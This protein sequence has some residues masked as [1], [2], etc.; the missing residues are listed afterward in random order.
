M[1]I[2]PFLLYILVVFSVSCMEE[3]DKIYNSYNYYYPDTTDNPPDTLPPVGVQIVF[4]APG[5]ILEISYDWREVSSPY[6]YN[7]PMVYQTDTLILAE[8]MTNVTRTVI[9][10]RVFMRS[11]T[12]GSFNQY[13]YQTFPIGNH[14]FIP[15]HERSN[16]ETY[17]LPQD[18]NYAF[19]VSV[20]TDDSVSYISP[21]VPFGLTYKV[22]YD[23][24]TT[25]LAPIADTLLDY[26]SGQ[27]LQIE[28]CPASPN[29]DS[30]VVSMRN[31]EVGLV[32]TFS[33]SGRYNETGT[34]L[35]SPISDYSVW[36]KAKNTF[37]VSAAS[38]TMH[39]HTREPIAPDNLEASTNSEGL[40][41][42][43]WS[44]HALP[45]AFL[46]SRCDTLSEW[47]TVQSI[48]CEDYYCPNSYTDSTAES[49][50]VYYYRI[51]IEYSVGTWWGLDS[52]G[53]W[54]P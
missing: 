43:H 4:P 26:N 46:I 6:Y 51:G 29:V 17:N 38:D 14:F 41:H 1:R 11:G 9:E 8:V 23:L 30:F 53:V 20:M 42:L 16:H 27:N 54:I 44:N 10:A 49:R 52:V 7:C 21:T 19:W 18:L 34:A 24:D 25:P 47:S 15:I 45:D 40:V 33:V 32:R 31:D 36:I 37:G 48:H 2:L 50:Q 39:I 28:W 13:S 22:N 5:E 3:G 12:N 35:F